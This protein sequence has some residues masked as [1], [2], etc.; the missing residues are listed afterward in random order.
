[1]KRHLITVLLIGLL[2]LTSCAGWRK[3]RTWTTGDKVA[4]GTLIA[5]TA[6]DLA[7]TIY[8]IDNG[9]REMNPML[10]DHPSP[11]TL[12]AV[13]AVV[14]GLIYWIAQ[15]MTSKERKVLYVPAGLGCFA[16]VHNYKVINK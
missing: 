4:L 16:A 6:A 8:N 9:L 1:M 2:I 13:N 14:T 10:G 11:G 15:Y 12:I 3:N 5:C 7:T